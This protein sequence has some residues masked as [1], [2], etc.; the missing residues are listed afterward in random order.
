[1][2]APPWEVA[3]RRATIRHRGHLPWDDALQTARLA[4]IEALSRWRPD[5]GRNEVNWCYLR[6]RGALWDERRRP[7]LTVVPWPAGLDPP[8]TDTHP[9]LDALDVAAAIASL[10]AGPREAAELLRWAY[11]L[12]A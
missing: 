8:T 2:E 5:G 1:M 12:V 4:A 10:D 7:R 3:A 6:A 11:D 9:A